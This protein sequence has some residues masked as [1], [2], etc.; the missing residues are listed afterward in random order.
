MTSTKTFT[1]LIRCYLTVGIC[2]AFTVALTG[3]GGKLSPV[4][5]KVT[6]KGNVVTGGDLSFAPMVRTK[7]DKEPGKSATGAVQQDGTYTLGTYGASDGAVVGRHSVSYTPPVMEYP[8]GK[9]PLPGQPRPRSGFEGLTVK[10]SEVEVK[11]GPNTIDIELV[12]AG[13]K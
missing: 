8:A 10:Q 3:C 2:F 4:S 5:G 12:P 6:Y 1:R 7:T 9:T 11:S 13:Q